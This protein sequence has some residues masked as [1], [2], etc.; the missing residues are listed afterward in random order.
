MFPSLLAGSFLGV[1][2]APLVPQF[3]ITIL[4]CFF[5]ISTLVRT[6][7][8]AIREF[9]KEQQIRK[10]QKAEMEAK[11][12]SS[13]TV[14]PINNEDTSSNSSSDRQSAN[15]TQC[16]ANSDLHE[17]NLVEAS[18]SSSENRDASEIVQ[19]SDLDSIEKGKSEEKQIN[20]FL[21]S[22]YE[23]EEMT[24][25]QPAYCR[26]RD[27]STAQETFTVDTENS[28][29]SQNS[30]PSESSAQRTSHLTDGS[31]ANN[32]SAASSSSSEDEQDNSH[33]AVS[34]SN[35]PLIDESLSPEQQAQLAKML[36]S[37]AHPPILKLLFCI[38]VWATMIVFSF[39]RG[40][41]GGT[42]SL[43]GVKRCGWVDWFLFALYLVLSL[44]L[45][46]FAGFVLI[47]EHKTKKQLHYPFADGDVQWRVKTAVLYPLFCI[48]AGFLAGFLGIGGAL[49]TSP[50]LMEMG[51]IVP[52]VT[53][54]TSALLLATS[55]ASTAQYAVS[56]FLPYDW[57]LFFFGL[58]IL[59][60]LVGTL[61]I[62]RLAIKYHRYSVLLF[63]IAL[64][65]SISLIISG[66]HGIYTI[67]LII[68]HGGRV[69]FSSPCK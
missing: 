40:G 39:A 22:S 63:S 33:P 50:V 7:Q 10:A 11:K 23:M 25:S 67:V 44:A 45:A 14:P 62:A 59:G 55:S 2:V 49:V 64:L 29:T 15:S 54:T 20:E 57:G 1:F 51:V 32:D 16:Q 66:F 26:K 19:K 43:F 21:Q 5:L 36:K 48:L 41:K 30:P 31:H 65:F 27:G 12:D 17:G 58:G 47:R 24:S 35:T 52:V 38:A 13:V 42:P 4:L 68:I 61:V 3:V 56:L 46:V 6:L 8:K 53:A 9:K 28:S 18:E 69:S 37:E 34:P 60:S